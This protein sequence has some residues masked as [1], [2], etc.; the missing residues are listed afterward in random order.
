MEATPPDSYD[1][2]GGSSSRRSSGAGEYMV[3]TGSNSDIV[4]DEASP[5][6]LKFKSKWERSAGKK[7]D[8]QQIIADAFDKL[9]RNVSNGAVRVVPLGDNTFEVRDADDM[10]LF[11]VPDSLNGYEFEEFVLD[12]YEEYKPLAE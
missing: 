2:D 9:S 6:D 8:R 11:T 4:F 10:A 1:D 5:G 7:A 3:P 12:R